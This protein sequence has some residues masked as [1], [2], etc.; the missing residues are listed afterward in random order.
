MDLAALSMKGLGRVEALELLATHLGYSQVGSVMRE[1]MK[2][3]FH[4]AI[5]RK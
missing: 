5:R 4:S 1:A 3:V 2:T